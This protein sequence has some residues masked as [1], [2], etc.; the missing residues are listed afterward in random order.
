MIKRL[1]IETIEQI[2]KTYLVKDFPANEV[3]PLENIKTMWEMDG[4]EGFGYYDNDVLKAYAFT[5]HEPS[6]PYILLD[7][8]A[9]VC[10]FRDQ[11]LG[12]KILRELK[13]VIPGL[14]ALIIETEDADKALNNTQKVERIR[15][16]QF[17]S[18]NG[19]I[20]SRF[21]ARVYQADYRIWYVPFDDSVDEE[22]IYD[23]YLEVYRF[24]LSERGYEENFKV[25]IAGAI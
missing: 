1:D 11:G 24:M 3:K 17:Y 12:G 22:N 18:R 19:V 4:Y 14:N 20:K 21:S 9:V 8:F 13:N 16:D 10:D 15:R 7:Y 5:C 6:S 25:E 23:A 2:Y